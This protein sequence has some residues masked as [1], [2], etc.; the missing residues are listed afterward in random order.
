MASQASSASRARS[1][2]RGD[3][4]GQRR[5]LVLIVDDDSELQEALGSA[6]GDHGF[7]VLRG[8]NGSEALRLLKQIMP[9]VILLDALM[10][11]LDGK[12]TL[13]AIRAEPRTAAIP[14]VFV[15]ASRLRAED[16][17]SA[18][19]LVRKPFDVDDLIALVERLADRHGQA[20]ADIG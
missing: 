11:V 12:G 16:V 3:A 5:V 8:W 7:D 6:L 4:S 14:V 20:L 13:E 17:P 15:T 9:D 10:P 18:Q 2:V 1:P 19:A